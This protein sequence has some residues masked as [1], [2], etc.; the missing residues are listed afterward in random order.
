MRSKLFIL[1]LL[2]SLPLVL[3]SAGQEK[4]PENSPRK[5][6]LETDL[7]PI[8]QEW[9]RPDRPGG[10]VAIIQ[11][12]EI[13]YKK[14]FGL[15]NVEYGLLNTPQ[16]VFDVSS[17]AEPVTG[18]AIAMLEEQGKLATSEPIRKYIPEL[19][20]CMDS[21][22]IAHLLYHTS[23][24]ADWFDLISLAGW[25]ERDV[26]TTGHVLKLLQRQRVLVFSPGSEY[27]YSRTDYTLLAELVKRITNESF[28]DWAWENIFK[29]LG[30]L[31]S[32]FRE[33]HRETI[34]NRAYSINYSYREGYLKG[35]DNLG[36]VGASSLYTSLDDFIKWMSNIQSQ[37]MGSA[38][39]L[40][41]M[42]T[43]G[44]LSNGEDA[45]HSYGFNVDSNKGLKRVFKNGSWGGF[46]AAFHYYPEAS[47]AVAIFSNWDYSW[48]DP[49]IHAENVARVCLKA[50]ME[51][52]EQA[53]PDAKKKEGMKINP[54]ILSQYQGEY[55]LQ[56]GTYMNI[57]M[58]DDNLM[59]FF[60]GGQKYQLVPISE[61]EF[62]FLNQY[63][64][65][66]FHKGKNGQIG[67]LNLRAGVQ[68][69]DAPRIER[70][71]LNQEQLKLHEGTYY[72]Q[73][74]DGRY[75]IRWGE[76]G[77]ILT[78]LRGGDIALTPESKNYFIA[79]SP[80]FRLI[81]FSKDKD[82]EI[83]GFRIDSDNLRP[84]LF[85]KIKK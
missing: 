58:E 13:V 11:K 54:S 44:K 53:K 30:M 28:R 3:L 20:E 77:L 74:T 36:V 16:T 45:G 81:V 39:V 50:L 59:L 9:E 76:N 52:G 62:Q 61:S 79:N 72:N 7:K 57:K 34:E 35:A 38:S 17:L 8:F 46:K 73:E 55:R 40:E 31:D 23:G 85:E 75:E 22:T 15:A 6:S 25:D 41:K 42:F 56:P 69:F 21:I 78:S 33:D 12:G 5:S 4:K 32:T 66:S 37:K 10:V 29:P 51:K 2:I 1:I 63:Y 68:N 67:R 83:I 84:F 48:N 65:V 71:N 24:L 19:P 64:T 26:I 80:I 82:G 27:R 49:A 47:F 70:V 18:M 60:P 14:C 43:S